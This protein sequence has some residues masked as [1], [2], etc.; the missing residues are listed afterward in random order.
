[1]MRRMLA[2]H[3]YDVFD[4]RDAEEGLRAVEG[5]EI[6]LLLTAVPVDGHD[7]AGQM[8]AAQPALRVL[9]IGEPASNR[10]NGTHA[11]VMFAIRRLTLPRQRTCSATRLS[12]RSKKACATHSSGAGPTVLPPLSALTEPP[13]LHSSDRNNCPP[14]P[15]SEPRRDIAGSHS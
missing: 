12:C 3:G 15:D 5:R 9:Y 8:T 4:A 1:M 11:P 14:Q 6:D 2:S 7:L 10:S 13:A